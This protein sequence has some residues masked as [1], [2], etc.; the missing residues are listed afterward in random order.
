MA[1]AET[2]RPTCP[3]CNQSDQ[4]KTLQA[5]YDSGVN[6]AAPPDMPTKRVSM[7]P[8]IFT[9]S[10]LVGICIFL[11][12]VLVG[13]LESA[14]PTLAFQRV[15]NG[16]AESTVLFPAWDRAMEI[17]KSMYYCARDNVVF[18]PKTNKVLSNE[19]VAKLRSMDEGSVEV[20]SAAVAGQ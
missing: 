12:I 11:I 18:D 6:K 13:G 10:I 20:Q 19:Q 3:V 8:Y 1:S 16:D 15:V 14:L 17:W 4:V 9:S 2:Q 7:M 5:A